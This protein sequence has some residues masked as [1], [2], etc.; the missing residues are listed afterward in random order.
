[1]IDVLPPMGWPLIV[2]GL[3]S[4]PL[5]MLGGRIVGLA[6]IAGSLGL[7]FLAGT[8]VPFQPLDAAL[9]A[10][11]HIVAAAGLLFARSEEDRWP[12]AA[13][14]VAAGAAV[15]ALASTSLL[16]LIAWT[17]V[18][19]V[20]SALI[21]MSSGTL[22]AIRA[23]LAYLL[24]QVLAGA[25]LLVALALQGDG[26]TPQTLE[27]AAPWLI[28]V[29]L[30][31]KAAMPPFHGWLIH[32][33]R[34]A[35]PTGTLFL[36]AFST[37]VAIIALAH[38]FAGQEMLVWIG[39]AVA[40]I[41]ALPTLVERDWRRLLTWA[42]VSQLGVM[43]IGVGLGD[44]AALDGVHLLAIGHVIYASLLFLAA[45]ILERRGQPPATLWPITLAAALSIGLPGLAGYVG[46][47][48][49]GEAMVHHGLFWA[50]LIVVAVGAVIFA[51]AGLRPLIERCRGGHGAV[52]S[53]EGAAALLLFGAGL[54]L[55]LGA[56]ALSPAAAA[57]W[58]LKPLLI[59]GAALAI[60]TVL[61]LGL[62]R[63]LPVQ[64]DEAL[65]WL[66]FPQPRWVVGLFTQAAW[67]G[68]VLADLGIR[69]ERILAGIGGTLGRGVN[70]IGRTLT[71]GGA[72][73][74]VLWTLALLAV[75]L[76]VSFG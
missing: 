32:A 64:H 70:Y 29:A 56:T 16:S 7:I 72:G 46:K 36:S 57:T 26:L 52:T 37:K 11:F 71:I 41:A 42:L 4:V 51:T 40:V 20:S 43:L 10:A 23:G 66:A 17:E 75:I 14:L 34:A 74:G 3:M 27:G 63:R 9:A 1:M 39:L 2:A 21:T 44:P 62:G 65:S 31:I 30:G 67:L 61:V 76:I 18:I 38:L 49:I 50:E 60:A 48:Q 12:I 47:A 33:Y 5:P 15:A 54:A 22:P 55:G 59:Q 53:G 73:D 35:S 19:A 25:L 58:G 69:V 24:L 68:L 13:G 8:P 28:L 6:A 45:G